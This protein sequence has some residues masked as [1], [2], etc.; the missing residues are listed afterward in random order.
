MKNLFVIYMLL[1][2]MSSCI[3]VETI[4]TECPSFNSPQLSNSTY[5]VATYGN[6][7]RLNI[8][9]VKTGLLYIIKSSYGDSIIFNPS[10][11]YNAVI[12]VYNSTDTGRYSIYCTDNGRR[13]ISPI[14]YFNISLASQLSCTLNLGD[15]TLSN[16]T[17]TS[18]TSPVYG[19]NN[20]NYFGAT[21]NLVGGTLQARFGARH[22]NITGAEYYTINPYQQS[23][24][25]ANQCQIIFTSSSYTYTAISGDVLVTNSNSTYSH[26]VKLCNVTWRRNDNEN[27]A[28]GSGWLT[29]NY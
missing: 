14:S 2:G 5:L 27:L 21:W 28:G 12:N 26:Y 1:L 25:G 16:S 15:F 7:V 11:Q 19:Q 9:N 23:S 13:C 22:Q 24:L 29:Y 3:K 6:S 20:G 18:S 17:P 10:N 4:G 8:N